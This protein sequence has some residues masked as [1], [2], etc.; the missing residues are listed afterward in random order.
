MLKKKEGEKKRKEPR[1]AQRKVSKV[2]EICFNS[3]CRGLRDFRTCGMGGN[4]C[5]SHKIARA[6]TK[7]K[8]GGCGA[9]M[10]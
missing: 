5:E 10:M 4:A 8:Q 7:H 1:G 9:I 2:S 6:A 3:F